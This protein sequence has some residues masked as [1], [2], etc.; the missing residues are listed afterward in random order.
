MTPRAR[1]A[2]VFCLARWQL[3]VPSRPQGPQPVLVP[4]SEWVRKYVYC[5]WAR[6]YRHNFTTRLPHALPYLSCSGRI[7]TRERISRQCHWAMGPELVAHMSGTEPRRKSE[8][9]HPKARKRRQLA[10]SIDFIAPLTKAPTLPG[11]WQ[12][13]LHPPRDPHVSAKTAWVTRGVAAPGDTASEAERSEDWRGGKTLLVLG[14]GALLGVGERGKKVCRERAQPIQIPTRRRRGL[15]F[16][17]WACGAV[18]LLRAGSRTERSPCIPATPAV[19]AVPPQ[20]QPA[21]HLRLL[22]QVCILV[23]LRDL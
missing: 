10:T 12:V 21:W 9:R 19:R 18:V 20:P 6:T 22:R 5:L 7:Q 15:P 11:Q 17:A 3:V 16:Q 8:C 1:A 13:G 14:V 23:S 4:P 2:S